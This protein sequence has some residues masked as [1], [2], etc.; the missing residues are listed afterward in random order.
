M[1]KKSRD[2]S[3]R[4]RKDLS[5]TLDLYNVDF[6]KK[7]VGNLF[8]KEDDEDIIEEEEPDFSPPPKR[9]PVRGF[10]DDADIPDRGVRKVRPIIRDEPKEALDTPPDDGVG[11]DEFEELKLVRAKP[12]LQKPQVSSAIPGPQRRPRLSRVADEEDDEEEA[13]EVSPNTS[14][15][16]PRARPAGSRY[17]FVEDE[18]RFSSFRRKPDIL[19]K[20]GAKSASKDK[21]E[22][23]AGGKG[24]TG[25]Q[26]PAKELKRDRPLFDGGYVEP[27]APDIIKIASIGVAGIALVIIIILLINNGSLRNQVGEA[28]G[29]QAENTRLQDELNLIR[30]ELEGAVESLSNAQLQ[31]QQQQEQEDLML[32]E[33][34]D[35]EFGEESGSMA[36]ADAVRTHTVVSG[37][38]LSRIANTF[39]GDS[40]QANI[41]R[42][43]EANNITNPNSIHVGQVLDIPN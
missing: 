8:D 20:D 32:M 27:G 34:P 35:D 25:R 11:D 15:G 1:D 41:Q 12:P 31:L 40:S 10:N 23:S 22:A 24:A 17:V 26:K 42:I 29:L 30:I 19:E 28:D 43:M 13:A 2:K 21:D 18:D 6:A 39:F 4:S 16:R 37:D 36:M 3:T 33:L 14:P 38:S 9:R 5:N 7:A